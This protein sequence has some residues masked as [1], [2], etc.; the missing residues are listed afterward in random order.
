MH[1]L[2]VT[3]I[4]PFPVNGGAKIR[5]YGLLKAV[6]HIADKVTAIIPNPEHVDLYSCNLD[7]VAYLEHRY[8]REYPVYGLLYH[9]FADRRLFRLFEQIHK[10]EEIDLVILDFWFLGHLISWFDRRDIPVIYGTHN[11][12]ADLARQRPA[13][14]PLQ[15]AY[16]FLN[17]LSRKWHERRFF[18]KADALLVVSNE[19]K[20]YH[21]KFVAKDKIFVVPNFLDTDRYTSSSKKVSDYFVV[22]ADFRV[23]MNDYGLKWFLK[24]VWAEE[25]SEKI[26]VL[27][28]GKGSKK[29]LEKYRNKYHTRN[30]EATGMVDNV[31]PYI[32]NAKAS[33]VPL[34]HGSGTRLKC[35]EAMA[36]R[37][38]LIA[39]SK[40]AEGISNDDNAICIAD[41]PEE[42]KRCMLAVNEGSVDNTDKAFGTFRK[43]YSLSTAETNLSSVIRNVTGSSIA[44]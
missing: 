11:S 28:V 20:T 34:L 17:Y 36:L 44:I 19:D 31:V 40:G 37:T 29:V 9:H 38:Q 3:R 15:R 12:Q 6:S 10:E 24:Y 4:P 35:I 22:S 32:A 18:D 21:S 7:R 14:N 42:F 25:L 5:A 33:I 41:T 39:T 8:P 27:L 30:I 43:Y 23:F 1:I 13:R 26:K 16:F 2:Y